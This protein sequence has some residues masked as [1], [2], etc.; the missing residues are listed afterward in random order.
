MSFVKTEVVL[1]DGSRETVYYLTEEGKE[2]VLNSADRSE[3]YKLKIALS[4]LRDCLREQLA[5]FFEQRIIRVLENSGKSW[6]RN[7][8]E[9][10]VG[11]DFFFVEV[12]EA[13]Q[14][15]LEKGEIIEKKGWIKLKKKEV[16][17]G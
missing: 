1:T 9:E 5:E 8:L 10:Y 7:V 13:V 3:V 16:S 2:R 6:R 12:H 11:G 15:L 14:N 4:I 17:E